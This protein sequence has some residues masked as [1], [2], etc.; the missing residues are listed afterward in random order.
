MPEEKEKSRRAWLSPSHL[1]ELTR[2][3][4]FDEEGFEALKTFTHGCRPSE[5]LAL[6][7][8]RHSKQHAFLEVVRIAHKT[9]EQVE[10]DYQVWLR[11]VEMAVKLGKVIRVGRDSKEENKSADQQ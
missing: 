2:C 1:K 9:P 11:F 8:D 3:G 6:V 10:A 7:R 4:C 5:A